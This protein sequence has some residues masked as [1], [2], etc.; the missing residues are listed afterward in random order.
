MPT[1]TLHR[2]G[3]RSRVL[4]PATLDSRRRMKSKSS[5]TALGSTCARSCVLFFTRRRS[6]SSKLIMKRLLLL[7]AAIAGV[8]AVLSGLVLMQSSTTW[9]HLPDGSRTRVFTVTQGT[10]HRLEFPTRSWQAH[11]QKLLTGPMTLNSIHHLMRREH[12]G[13]GTRSDTPSTVV[14][15]QSD[16]SSVVSF[17][18]TLITSGGNRYRS[19]AANGATTDGYA[20]TSLKFPVVPSEPR[21]HLEA[22]INGKALSFNLANPALR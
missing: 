19:R 6:L 1:N 13:T 11:Y 17:E 18:A 15:F 9:Q 4:R 7:L 5:K 8:A 2:D 12:G 16:T 20:Y 10:T 3:I 21:L 14:W 22:T